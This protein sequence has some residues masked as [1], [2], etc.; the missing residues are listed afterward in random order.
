MTPVPAIAAARR[1]RARKGKG[2][3]LRDE[4]LDATERLLLKL[5]SAEAVSIRSVADAVGVTPP[6]IYRHFT[7]KTEL[8]FEVSARHFAAFDQHLARAGDGVADPVDRLR[9]YGLAYMRFG[10]AN[11]EPYRIMFMN[12]ADET[13]EE[14]VAVMRDDA[15]FDRVMRCVQDGIDAGRFRPEY[16]DAYR[17][18][19]GLW[20]RVHGLTSLIVAKPTF[21]WPE[22]RDGFIEEYADICLGGMLREG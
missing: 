7:D 21:P 22:D 12:P 5:G 11:P 8:I 18:T 16:T 19:V 1:P 3:A 17:L 14:Y 2:A 4:I 10:M 9:S 15:S 13:P 6:S 20:A